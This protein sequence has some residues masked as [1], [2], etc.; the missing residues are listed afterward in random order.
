MS[1]TRFESKM[2]NIANKIEMEFEEA[3]RVNEIKGLT[4]GEIEGIM[5]LKLEELPEDYREFILTYGNLDTTLE[6]FGITNVS[7]EWE[8]QPHSL[9]EYFGGAES[10]KEYLMID[11]AGEFEVVLNLNDGKV[12]SWSPYDKGGLVFWNKSFSDYLE[13]RLNDVELMVEDW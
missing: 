13:E 1:I 2:R 7:G 4:P 6:V 5:G 12:Y 10:P 11:D 9:R 8:F 3:T